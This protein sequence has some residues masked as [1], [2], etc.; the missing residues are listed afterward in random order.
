VAYPF[1]VLQK[2]G[3]VNDVVGGTKVAVF[4]MPGT[5]SALDGNTVAGGRDVGT[6]NAF[7]RELDGQ[8]LTF[9]RSGPLILDVET[10]SEWNVLGLAVR[11]KLAGKQLALV[12]AVNHFWFSWAAFKPKT[13]VYQP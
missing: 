8:T 3:V 4:W 11:G 1:D 7:A 10:G 13:R 6:A 2:V 5:A 9:T 12:A